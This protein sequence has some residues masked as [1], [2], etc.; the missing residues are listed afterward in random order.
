MPIENEKILEVVN[1]VLDVT[2]DNNTKKSILLVDDSNIQLRAMTELLKDKYDVEEEDLVSAEIEIVPAGPARD[3]GLD[4]SMV[5]GYGH[6]PRSG[7]LQHYRT[8]SDR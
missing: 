1:K 3:Y 2:C 4:R 8:R 7:C 6:D 5:A